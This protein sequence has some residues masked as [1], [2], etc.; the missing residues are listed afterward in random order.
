MT[1]FPNA[2]RIADMPDLGAVTDA[3]SVVG[4]R[5]GSGRFSAP[6]LRSYLLEAPMS[7]AIGRNLVHNPLFN[8][9]QRGQGPFTTTA[10]Y[11]LDRWESLFSADTFSLSQQA[12][13][14]TNRAQIGDESAVWFLFAQTTGTA[15]AGSFSFLQHKIEDVRRLAGKTVTVSFYAGGTNGAKV[16]VSIDQMFGSGGSPSASVFGA[17]QSVTIT[18]AWQRCSLTFT[19]PSVAGKSFGTNN[20]SYSS[21]NVWFSAGTNS[22]GR[23]G[24]IGVQT[25][26]VGIWGVQLEIGDVMTPLEKPDPRYDLSNCQRF[27][28]VTAPY[29][30]GGYAT[31]GT[32]VFATMTLPTTMRGAPTITFA[33]NSTSGTSALSMNAAT[34]T[35]VQL[36]TTASATGGFFAFADILASADL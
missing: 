8:I 30:I 1:Q 10:S 31:S 11:T 9:A 12:H 36:K 25:S 16:G 19:L 15:G 35:V 28:S 6:A 5:A 22:A 3:S 33:N 7:G 27:Y 17:G 29:I 20:D 23:S 32:V 4:E 26:N 2:I 34:T 14:D 13:S 21:M 18:T 24:N